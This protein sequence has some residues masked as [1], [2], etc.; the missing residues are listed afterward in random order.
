MKSVQQ[1]YSGLFL[2]LGLLGGS[3]LTAQTGQLGQLYADGLQKAAAKELVIDSLKTVLEADSVLLAEIKA[4][5]GLKKQLGT[6]QASRQNDSITNRYDQEKLRATA[7]AGNMGNV[8]HK[9]GQAMGAAHIV[10]RIYT[11]NSTLSNYLFSGYRNT[12]LKATADEEFSL[13]TPEEFQRPA[14]SKHNEL[15]NALDER[16]ELYKKITAL[17]LECRMVL[18]E[19]Y[20]K[21]AVGDLLRRYASV[22]PKL[23]QFSPAQ[24]KNIKENDLSRLEH[25]CTDVSEFYAAL[26]EAG[27]L[28]KNGRKQ[29]A[30]KKIDDELWRF[31]PKEVY[32]Y[33]YAKVERIKQLINAGEKDLLGK[34]ALTNPN[35]P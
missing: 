5:P 2:L 32:R 9:L 20:D 25:Y 24:Q 7:L 28:V 33:M 34:A 17:R 16:V 15:L 23:V 6:L 11:E 18:G 8:H 10:D 19:A 26:V 30:V 4:L 21:N 29:A 27:G 1:Y 3:C 35:C 12:V 14:D 31:E 13:I 22:L